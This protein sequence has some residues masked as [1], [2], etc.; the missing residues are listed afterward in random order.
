MSELA[1]LGGPR[2]IMREPV[3]LFHWPIVTREDEEA[4]L[5]VLRRGAMSGTD[6]TVRFEDEFARWMGV[7]HALAYPSGTES[8]RAALWACGI[9]AGDE[10]ICLQ[11]GHL[12]R[13]QS[14]AGAGSSRSLRRSIPDTLCLDPRDVERRIERARAL[15][16]WSATAATRP[17][18]IPSWPSRAGM[19]CE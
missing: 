18:W 16:W 17:R 8:I 1:V 12:G 19:V 13:L 11:H 3:D 9:G 6:V 2:A 4:V 15:S 14:G 5:E 7:K 10:V